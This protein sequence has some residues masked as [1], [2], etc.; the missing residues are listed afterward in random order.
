[1]IQR[2]PDEAGDPRA[3]Y[4]G[5]SGEGPRGE[6]ANPLRTGLLSALLSGEETGPR[7]ALVSW[8][9]DPTTLV[10]HINGVHEAT[11]VYTAELGG[12]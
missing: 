11:F 4:G 12:C 3:L 9:W 6:P 7:M 1:V 8:L 2:N 10:F 5:S